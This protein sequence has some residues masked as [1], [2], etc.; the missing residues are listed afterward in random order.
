MLPPRSM[1][2][3]KPQ[4]P[5][6]RIFRGDGVGVF[7]FWDLYGPN[8]EAAQRRFVQALARKAAREDHEKSLV[9]HRTLPRKRVLKPRTD[10]KEP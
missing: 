8:K 4:E 1:R 9:D 5:I 6:V 3:K 7:C 10:H 2:R